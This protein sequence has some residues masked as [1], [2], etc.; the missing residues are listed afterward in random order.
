MTVLPCGAEYVRDRSGKEQPSHNANRV[1][2][3]KDKKLVSHTLFLSDP[4]LTVYVNCFLAK[5]V[6]EYIS[7]FI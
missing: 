4:P 1:K 6:E 2:Q 5:K 3:W 7:V